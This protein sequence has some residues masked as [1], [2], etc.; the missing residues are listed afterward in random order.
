[1]KNVL[2]IAAWLLS[3][4]FLIIGLLMSIIGYPS[5]EPSE[6]GDRYVIDRQET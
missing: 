4:F 1:M 3:L 2:G 5:P 6:Q